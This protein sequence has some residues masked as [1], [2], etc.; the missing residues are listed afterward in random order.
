VLGAGCRAASAI[1]ERM[2]PPKAAA[3][4]SR[5]GIVD[6]PRRG[7]PAIGRAMRKPL[8]EQVQQQH[9]A[10]HR[11]DKAAHGDARRGAC[12]RLA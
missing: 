3:V 6:A 9:R 7:T 8:A 1:V 4:V 11:A 2:R 10:A 5:D 12:S